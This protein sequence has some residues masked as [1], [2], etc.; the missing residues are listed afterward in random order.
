MKIIKTVQNQESKTL[1]FEDENV[2]GRIVVKTTH[3]FAKLV[4]GNFI[5]L[6]D[7]K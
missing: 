2:K 5:P 3:P 4:V 7:H 1:Y 6:N